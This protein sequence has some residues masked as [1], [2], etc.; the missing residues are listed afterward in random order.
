MRTKTLIPG[1]KNSDVVRIR[2]CDSDIPVYMTVK[3]ALQGFGK[4]AQSIAVEQ[5][6]KALGNVRKDPGAAG[7][8]AVGIAGNWQ[9]INLQLDYLA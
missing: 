2:F 5:G 7:S 6:L 1:L 8:A 4:V 3:N 9:G